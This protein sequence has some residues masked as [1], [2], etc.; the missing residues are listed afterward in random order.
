MITDDD[1]FVATIR[2]GLPCCDF[3]CTLPFH[4]DYMSD[5]VLLFHY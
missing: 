2:V 5:T 1:D 4:D 3:S